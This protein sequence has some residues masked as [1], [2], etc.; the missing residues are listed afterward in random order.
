M[1]LRQR[2]R[3]LSVVVGLAA[4]MIA[5]P[6]FTLLATNAAPAGAAGDPNIAV[7]VQGQDPH[8]GVAQV[9]VQGCNFHNVVK[10]WYGVHDTTDPDPNAWYGGWILTHPADHPFW[11]TVDAAPPRFLPQHCDGG[12]DGSRQNLDALVNVPVTAC[13]HQ[14]R[15]DA[16][17]SDGTPASTVK[18]TL[19]CRTSPQISVGQVNV[20][21][22]DHIGYG[23]VELT[24]QNALPNQKLSIWSGV[25]DTVAGKDPNYY[26]GWVGTDAT[27]RFSVTTTNIP[28]TDCGDWFDA[29][30]TD[31]ASVPGPAPSNHVGFRLFCGPQLL[32]T[33][34]GFSG[35]YFT[36]GQPVTVTF[37]D[38]SGAPVAPARSHVASLPSSFV[39]P[40]GRV[41][42]PGGTISGGLPVCGGFQIIAY[43]A[44]QVTL[45]LPIPACIN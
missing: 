11:A 41:L 34:N 19:I 22:T 33:T 9:G 27:G 6:L 38:Y 29:Y 40:F 26:G 36:P 30:V 32:R 4:G 5:A 10:V 25:H 12:W 23:Q 3:R 17:D 31:N 20:S 37:T 16:T 14:M 2:I 21:P 39:T 8:V 24:G 44:G 43:Q 35:R 7:F 13:G 45:P 28:R 18:F 1:G 42:L 15:A